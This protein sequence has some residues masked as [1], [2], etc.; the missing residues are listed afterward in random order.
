MSNKNSWIELKSTIMKQKWFHFISQITK[1]HHV[2]KKIFTFFV[3]KRSQNR[4]FTRNRNMTESSK[5]IECMQIVQLHE[6]EIRQT[7]RRE[8][9]IKYKCEAKEFTRMRPSHKRLIRILCFP[10]FAQF[11]SFNLIWFDSISLQLSFSLLRRIIFAYFS[12][13]Y[14][15]SKLKSSFSFWLFCA[16]K[17]KWVEKQM[18]ATKWMGKRAYWLNLMQIWCHTF[19]STTQR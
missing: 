17:E 2:T 8:N 18:P 13:L 4:E 6:N 11:S 14:L 12:I 19:F 15:R 3:A 10:H 5:P 9:G 7:R 16:R 1:I